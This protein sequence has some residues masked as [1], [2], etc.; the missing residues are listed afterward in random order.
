MITEKELDMLKRKVKRER[1]IDLNYYKDSFIIRRV[2]TRLA[3]KRMPAIKYIH[4]LDDK[5]YKELF[6]LLSINVTEFFRDSSVYEMFQ[7]LILPNLVYYKEGIKKK[8]I[9]IWSAGCASGEEPYSIAIMLR[10][11]FKDKIDDWTIT[12]LGTDIDKV[13]LERA[14][15]GI[16]TENRVKNVDKQLIDKY[17]FTDNTWY[18]VNDDI[19]SMVRFKIHDLIH[20]Q[21]E[22]NFDVVFC[23][24]VMIYF[25][26]ELQDGLFE[27]FYRALNKYGFLI[28]GKTEGVLGAYRQHFAFVD[29]PERIYRKI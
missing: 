4:L 20:D 12:V 23:R 10:E 6:K 29:I 19:K 16:F 5:E 25:S 18:E 11:F 8:S 22:H 14:K 2:S 26:K 17:F 28:L 3:Q 27:H 1:G 24:N 9:R 21:P 7:D 13:A 15:L